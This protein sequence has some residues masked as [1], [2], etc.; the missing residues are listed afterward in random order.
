MPRESKAARRERTAAIIEKLQQRYPD[1]H[2]A[3]VHRSPLELLVAVI[4][5]AQCTD[6]RVNIVTKDLFRN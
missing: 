5:S 3:L 2:C 4:L 6:E 1:A